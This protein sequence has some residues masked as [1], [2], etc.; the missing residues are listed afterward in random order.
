MD[1][2]D[3][4]ELS[5]NADLDTEE[6]KSEPEYYYYYYYDYQDSGIDISHELSTYEPLPTPLPLKGGEEKEVVKL[7]AS[8]EKEWDEVYIFWKCDNV[9]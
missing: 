1:S 9:P 8:K 4:F 6:D 5:D 7:E 2:S 3:D